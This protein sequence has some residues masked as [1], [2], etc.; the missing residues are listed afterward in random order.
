MIFVNTESKNNKAISV[1]V[2][3]IAILFLFSI[4][5]N[6]DGAS[7][8]T[9]SKYVNNSGSDNN[10]GNTQATASKTIKKGIEGSASSSD[11]T[12]NEIII[13]AGTYSGVD[14]N[15]IK[16]NKNISIYSAKAKG[17]A[18]TETIIS[19]NNT[20]RIFNITPGVTVNIYGINFVNGN[21]LS[22]AFEDGGGAICIN[23]S[24]VKITN[25]IFIKNSASDTQGIGGAIAVFGGVVNVKSCNFILNSAI[26]EGGAISVSYNS[27]SYTSLVVS[28]CNFTGN[29][30]NFGGAVCVSK[31]N[32]NVNDCNFVNN[33]A[34]TFGGAVCSSASLML[35][36]CNFTGNFVNGDPSD[37]GG[38]GGAVYAQST[39]TSVNDCNFISNS[40]S[41]DGGAINFVYGRGNV[42]G[43]NFTGNIANFGGVIFIHMVDVDMLACN[44][45]N[46]SAT[47]GN[48]GVVCVRGDED[49]VHRKFIVNMIACN[50]TDNF[51]SGVGGAVIVSAGGSFNLNGCDFVNN[52]ANFEGGAV[53]VGVDSLVN[54]SNCDFTN[55]SAIRGGAIY[56]F[57]RLTILDS[58]FKNNNATEGGAIYNRYYGTIYLIVNACN[59]TGNYAKKDGGVIWS[60]GIFN[61]TSCN[62]FNNHAKG[63]GGVLYLYGSDYDVVVSYCR[64]FNNS[65][66]YQLFNDGTGS[67]VA[68]L[69]CWGT[70]NG[71]SQTNALV[72][73]W[74]VMILNTSATNV[75]VGDLIKY[76]YYFLL[77]NTKG[78]LS[79]DSKVAT[80][81][82]KFS[83]TFKYNDVIIRISDAR[84][85]YEN[86]NLKV[87][88]TFNNI[89]AFDNGLFVTNLVFNA[90]ISPS[91]GN[92]KGNYTG[93][94]VKNINDEVIANG[95]SVPMKT[96]GVPLAFGLLSLIV[97]V[98]LLVRKD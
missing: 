61:M 10:N 5:I 54:M 16:I 35:S 77:N 85:S 36:T 75:K 46:N 94:S 73:N 13:A 86:L 89:S 90:T 81:M 31:G 42:N 88:S 3:L 1:L 12:A 40:A 44:F 25:C 70:N 60:E 28:A 57:D 14:N 52:S 97:S 27:V 23:N 59:F 63:N 51:A 65:G 7:A 21:A 38:S 82:P 50:F 98:G 17:L 68:N 37:G 43:C 39:V 87:K 49:I 56:N 83:V 19:G 24:N 4:A 72:D 58:T 62:L 41:G 84:R 66:N 32:G 15:N 91:N 6:I 22:T 30:A 18:T 79:F 92:Y 9:S 64:L 47:A 34:T 2:V 69:N 20:R 26:G 96:T 11:S 33:L 45:Y 8:A 53:Y 74:F 48:G 76:N 93:D 78:K 55:N 71:S 95:Q 67:V 29:I 80:L